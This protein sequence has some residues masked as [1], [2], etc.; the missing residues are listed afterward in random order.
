M[1]L[2]KQVTLALLTTWVCLVGQLRESTASH[3]TSAEIYWE[4]L[5]TG[6]DAGK[7]V[8]YA[9]LYVDCSVNPTI[10]SPPQFDVTNVPTMTS[11]ATT[12]V[13]GYPQDATPAECGFSCAD[14]I[15]D[16]SLNKWL[17]ASAPVTIPGP[18]PAD[19]YT[20]SFEPCCRIEA[21]NFAPGANTQVTRYAM[22]MYPYNNQN[23]DP[24]YDSGPQFSEPPTSLRCAGYP[25]RYNPNAIDPDLDSLSYQ[26]IDAQTQGGMPMNYAPGYSGTSPFPGGGTTLDPV[27]GQLEYNSSPSEAGRYSVVMAVDS[28]RCGQRIST[29]TR[30]MT[31]S[32][33]ACT[34][35]NDVPVISAPTWTAPATASGYEVTVQAGDLV[36]FTLSGTDADLLNGNP[37]TVTLNVTGAQIGSDPSNP[38][39]DCLT[40]PCATA[41]NAPSTATGGV[42]TEFN[43]QTTCEH[44]GYVNECG[45]LTNTYNFLFN[46][47]DNYCPA[48]GVNVVNVAVTVVGEPIIDSPDPHCAS[49]AANGD[50]TLSW[51][52]VTDNNVPPSFFEYVIL[53]ST[54]PTGPFQE[55][56]TVADINS[57][58]YIHSSAN[59]VA[60][61]TTSGPNYYVIRTR[62]GCLDSQLEAPV[63]SMASIYLTVTNNITTADLA[64]NA[65][66]TPN[67][68]STNGLYNVWRLEPGGTWT[69]IGTTN[70]LYYSDPVVWCQDELITY[71]VELADNLPCT[72]VSNEVAETLNNPLPPDPQAI[73]S[74]SVDPIS[75]LVT[76]GWLPNASVNTNQ[77]NIYLNPDQLAWDLTS[78]VMGYNTTS[79]TDST[80]D[81]SAGPVWY[82]MTATNDCG[83][84]LA[85]GSGAD[86]TNRHETIWLQTTVDGCKRE[87]YLEWTRYW[88]WDEGIK[89]YDIYASKDNGPF[90]KIGTVADSV[91]TFTHQ[92]LDEEATYCHFVRA[93][94][95]NNSIRV[96]S[97]SN[98]TC[99][100][101]Y[102]PKRPDYGYSYET[103]VIPGNTGVNH[104]FFVDST[105]GYL[106][107]DIQRGTDPLN[108]QSIWFVPF[109]PSTQY[110]SYTDAGARPGSNSYYY[111]V[112]GVDSCD[113]NADTLNITRTILLEAEANSDRTN[114]LAW[115]HY[116]S[117]LGDIEGYNIYRTYNGVLEQIAAVPPTQLT[118]TDSI[119]EIID[120]DGDF[121]Y[122]I[123]AV[124]GVGTP[125]G[126]TA[127]VLF[128]QTSLSN[129]D[130][131]LQSP[132]IFV[133]NA[134]VPDGVNSVFKPITVYADTENYLLQIYDRWGNR[135]FESTDPAVGW[136]GTVGG[137]DSAVGAYAFLLS[138]RSAK[139][140]TYVKR[141]TITLIR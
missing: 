114:T 115:N 133:P 85:A 25:L 118:Y 130:C 132:N 122:Y 95:N 67:L 62:S 33:I 51:D 105:A 13:P 14:G 27:T 141:G 59:T 71:R 45:K 15:Q 63:D 88:Y 129:E 19:G 32:F 81:P 73:D 83:E 26:L 87:A 22:T 44:V 68:P 121:C 21:T 48:S 125:V 9:V 127:P 134:F 36:N 100:Y 3:F 39:S 31:I 23:T 84:G 20:F 10:A 60:P 80:A 74:V 12:L 101:V 124:E 55:I 72:S 41:T 43:W 29:A 6:P 70:N 109:D 42:T 126:T 99:S 92:G 34:E 93:V 61:P 123:E 56:G 120:G 119:E 135:I 79:W 94:Q 18:P 108:L 65:V 78:S 136:D 50:I 138:V 37:Q 110:Y 111:S 8:F 16:I 113:L 64:W 102:V 117:W 76:I 137:K 24:C 17:F 11:L 104:F 4:C 54:S 96:T 38:N 139:G 30:D 53:H 128:A 106:G 47:K 28:W 75:G 52:P 107:F 7:F 46:F 40:T 91:F 35:P 112:I 5:T 131:A 103:T 97:S 90:E 49:T 140:N 57:G 86:G 2:I 58:T 98:P 82:Q 89:Q 77:Y 116:Q 1:N 66:A 69:L